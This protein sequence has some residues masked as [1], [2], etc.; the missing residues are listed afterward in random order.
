MELRGKRVAI[1][2]ASSGIGLEILKLLL[3]NGCR[4]A[5]CAR[6]IENVEIENE[7]GAVWKKSC[8][9][10]SVLRHRI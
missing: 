5:A 3:A 10:R 6:H 9:Y 1:T 7:N 2:G 8:Y 4:V